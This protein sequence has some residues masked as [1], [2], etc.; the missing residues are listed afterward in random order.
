MDGEETNTETGE[1]TE[2]KAPSIAS[3]IRDV[4]AADLEQGSDIT[5]AENKKKY[6][7]KAQELGMASRSAARNCVTTNSQKVIEAAG[8]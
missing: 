6:V 4:M 2:A 5:T 8:S 7:D 3:Q 1:N